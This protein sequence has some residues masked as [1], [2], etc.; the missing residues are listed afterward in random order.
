MEGGGPRDLLLKRAQSPED[1]V[2]GVRP[3]RAGGPFPTP[4]G[5]VSVPHS[6]LCP[7]PGV[8]GPPSAGRRPPRRPRRAASGTAWPQIP[9]CPGSRPPAL[10]LRRR[11]PP[12]LL[13]ADAPFSACLVRQAR[14]GDTGQRPPRLQVWA[15]LAGRGA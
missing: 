1:P 7:P 2:V 12:P 9:G 10:R 11:L 15:T 3:P 14:P 5:R 8:R 4:S 6:Y 13:R